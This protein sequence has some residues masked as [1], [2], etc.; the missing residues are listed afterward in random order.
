MYFLCF[1]SLRFR[2]LLHDLSEAVDVDDNSSVSLSSSQLALSVH[3]PKLQQNQIVFSAVQNSSAEPIELSLSN[4][5]NFSGT[6]SP[7]ASNHT[8]LSFELPIDVGNMTEED[9]CDSDSPCSHGLAVEFL[10]YSN[11]SELFHSD[12]SDL[13]NPQLASAVVSAKF[14]GLETHRFQDRKAKIFFKAEVQGMGCFC[15]KRIPCFI[16]CSEIHDSPQSGSIMLHKYR[17]F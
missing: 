14:S 6:L 7:A 11:G 2:S 13:Q 3:C 9:M 12:T 8:L 10:V 4:Q 1:R 17:Q 15:L 16:C 5:S